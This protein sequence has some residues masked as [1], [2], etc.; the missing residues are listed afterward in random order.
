MA[1][2]DTNSNAN[3]CKIAQKAP[4]SSGYE[5]TA[6]FAPMEVHR[7]NWHCLNLFRSPYVC[8]N[9]TRGCTC[10]ACIV[11]VWLLPTHFGVSSSW[12]GPP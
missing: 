7:R 12:K 11:R 2:S 1:G 4:N 5:S 3:V 6:V 8:A 10:G 9:V